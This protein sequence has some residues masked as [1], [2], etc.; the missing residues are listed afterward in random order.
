MPAAHPTTVR[1]TPDIKSA[2]QAFADEMGVTFNAALKVLLSEALA[3][4]GR[5]PHKQG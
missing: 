4:R 3:A 5:H 1:L 2:V